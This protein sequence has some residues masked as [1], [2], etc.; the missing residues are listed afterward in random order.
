MK[1][2]VERAIAFT[3]E[4]I[5]KEHAATRARLIEPDDQ[6]FEK[7]RVELGLLGFVGFAGLYRSPG[8]PLLPREQAEAR[9]QTQGNKRG[10]VRFEVY[11]RGKAAATYAAYL[12]SQ[13]ARTGQPFEAAERLLIEKVRG[14]FRF[15]AREHA[16]FVCRGTGTPDGSRCLRCNG[17][18]WENT[19]GKRIALTSAPDERYEF[20]DDMAA[21]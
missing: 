20:D 15:V 16:C 7:L 6:V 8:E 18:V 9:L 10:L 12:T 17:A 19:G 1:A 11:R 21:K 3:R 4:Y 13:F 14:Q 5:G 2:D